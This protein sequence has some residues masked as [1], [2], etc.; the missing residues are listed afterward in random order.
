ME[1]DLATI[2]KSAAGAVTLMHDRHA[3]FLIQ[4]AEERSEI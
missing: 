3:P 1:L 4:L 2:G